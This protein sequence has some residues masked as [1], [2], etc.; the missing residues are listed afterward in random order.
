MEM[1]KPL[2]G[3]R[4]AANPAAG[5]AGDGDGR[6]RGGKEGEG[7]FVGCFFGGP[8]LSKTSSGDEN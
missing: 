4:P 3:Q 5:A 2:L 7:E 1:V 8:F 6:L